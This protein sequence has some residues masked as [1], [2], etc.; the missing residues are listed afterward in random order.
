M[1]NDSLR[2]CQEINCSKVLAHISLT[3]CKL[4]SHLSIAQAFVLTG[5]RH[6]VLFNF[7]HPY[8]CLC[9]VDRLEK[10]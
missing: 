7:N 2:R 1:L 4:Q 3:S 8:P 6:C 10:P 9:L 5:Q